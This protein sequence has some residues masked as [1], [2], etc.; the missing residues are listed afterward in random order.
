LIADA[1]GLTV[2]AL[3]PE[4]VDQLDH[5]IA[6]YLGAKRDTRDRLDRV[7]AADPGCPLGHCLDGY[8]HLLTCQGAAVG[9]ARAAAARAGALG[10]NRRESLHHEALVAW[11]DGDLRAAT[12][13]WAVL[14]AD[15]P[16]DLL[17]I[18][19]SQFVLSYLGESAGIRD[20]VA[21][22]LPRWQPDDAGYGFLLGCH[23]YGLEEAGEYRAAEDAGL[24]AIGLGPEDIWAAHA[25]A[26]VREM[27]G[28]R[29]EGIEWIASLTDRWTDCGNFAHHLRWHEALFELELERFDR[30]LELYDREVRG[31]PSDQYLDLANAVS[32]L[33]RLEQSG[34]DVGSRWGELAATIEP[35]CHDHTLVFVD[36]HYVMALAAAPAMP[37]LERLLESCRRKSLTGGTEAG[38]M[39]EVGLPLAAAIVS[40]RRGRFGEVVD[41]V[42][43]IRERIHKIG[44]SHAQR[45]L[46]HQLLIDGAWRAGR[47]DL[48]RE[49]VEERTTR[50]PGN[51]WGWKHLGLILAAQGADA[52]AARREWDR[53]QT[54]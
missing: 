47:L 23:A 9:A 37:A 28:R 50:R 35:H 8:L 20:A 53:L 12:A 22:V 5:S 45:D 43:P 19:V 24:R 4:V 18:K 3:N 6:G 34:A 49:L 10:K 7:L 44:G 51:L 21:R 26:H 17:A 42:A 41:L 48:A 16:R 38:V 39:A 54:T 31:Q 2:T 15:H 52:G 36:L 25:V 27:E 1:R 46:F 11:V 13:R 32:L 14:L 30:V 29:R 40:H 33:W